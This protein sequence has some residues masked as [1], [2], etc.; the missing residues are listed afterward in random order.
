MSDVK[1]T[2][3]RT[4]KHFLPRCSVYHVQ[5][6]DNIGGHQKLEQTPLLVFSGQLFRLVAI[7]Y[8]RW[9]FWRA[10]RPQSSSHYT[11]LFTATTMGDT[12]GDRAKLREG[13]EDLRGG[14]PSAHYNTPHPRPFS[15]II[16]SLLRGCGPVTAEL[17][18]GFQWQ[19][20]EEALADLFGATTA[21]FACNS[22][23]ATV[24]ISMSDIPYNGSTP[25]ASDLTEIELTVVP[26]NFATD[27]GGSSAGQ[28]VVYTYSTQ[29][30]ADHVMVPNVT[31]DAD[32]G[33]PLNPESSA[34][35]D[36]TSRTRSR[37]DL[38]ENRES[39]SYSGD[40]SILED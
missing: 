22:G 5:P 7:S 35:Q 20:D 6:P 31:R 10:Q 18:R 19:V 12:N 11:K 37:S 30:T 40:T 1:M 34:T 8:H 14:T 38:L 32:T 3:L 17:F 15:R 2:L 36:P 23:V 16:P 4:C 9:R 29:L 26:S 13:R 24:R 21:E 33:C 25:V 39:P 27:P 28:L